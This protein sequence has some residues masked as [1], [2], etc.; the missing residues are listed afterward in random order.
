MTAV[1]VRSPKFSLK[2]NRSKKASRG[3]VGKNGVWVDMGWEG[4]WGGGGGGGTSCFPLDFSSCL[5]KV[6]RCEDTTVTADST[7]K[8]S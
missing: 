8:G 6:E 7:N 5:L 4:S 1:S 3:P 2:W